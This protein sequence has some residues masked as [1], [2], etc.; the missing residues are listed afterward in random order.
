MVAPQGAPLAT[1]SPLVLIS[2]SPPN[3]LV[4]SL[5]TRFFGNEK[6]IMSRRIGTKNRTAAFELLLKI[7]ATLP[8]IPRTD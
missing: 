6:M 5:L 8:T 7:L 3:E 4:T 1:P 2:F